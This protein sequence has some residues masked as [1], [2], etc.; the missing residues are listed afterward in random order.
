MVSTTNKQA[1]MNVA[2]RSACAAVNVDVMATC[3]VFQHL[4]QLSNVSGWTKTIIFLY[5]I[6]NRNAIFYPG[7]FNNLVLTDR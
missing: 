6:F 2:C 1:C 5:F 7:I 3:E 4:K